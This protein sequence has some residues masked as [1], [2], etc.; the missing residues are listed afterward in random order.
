[1][2]YTTFSQW[3]QTIR[4]EQDMKQPETGMWECLKMLQQL[5]PIYGSNGDYSLWKTKHIFHPRKPSNIAHTH[6]LLA[7]VYYIHRLV[8]LILVVI[9]MDNT[10]CVQE[11]V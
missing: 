5:R 9:N 2:L 11:K 7:L 6:T 8:L 1:M 3:I 4:A 10:E